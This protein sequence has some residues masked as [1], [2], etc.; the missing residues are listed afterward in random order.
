MGMDVYGV[1]NPDAYF[2]NNVWAWR[3]LATLIVEK[4]PDIAKTCEHWFTNDGDGLD[5]EN[6]L[7]LADAL[8]ADLN[9][10]VIQ[11]EQDEFQR[12]MNAVVDEP[13]KICGGTG[14]R[15]APPQV[16]PGNMHCNGCDGKGTRRP[17]TTMYH[18]SVE[19]VREFVAFLRKC[20]GFEIY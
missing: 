13:C 11:Q 15:A 6:S 4:Y 3:P 2:R 8:E 1:K 10:G 9:N 7:K 20:G 16:G 5:E 18:F 17:L 12:Q 19:N 14:K